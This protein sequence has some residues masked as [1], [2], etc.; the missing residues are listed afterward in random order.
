MD[1]AVAASAAMLGFGSSLSRVEE[2]AAIGRGW[3]R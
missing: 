1:H 2:N 3:S